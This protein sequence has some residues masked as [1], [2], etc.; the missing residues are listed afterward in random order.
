MLII[1]YPDYK[2]RYITDKTQNEALESTL[3][4][5]ADIDMEDIILTNNEHIDLTIAQCY[6]PGVETSLITLGEMPEL[7]P[8]LTYWLI[9]SGSQELD[10]TFAQIKE[11]GFTYQQVVDTG[12]LGT[13]TIFIYKIVYNEGGE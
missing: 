12:N 3:E 4:A 9:I 2:E 8:D 6:Y 1:F 10:E 7:N 11:Q 13:H 5:T